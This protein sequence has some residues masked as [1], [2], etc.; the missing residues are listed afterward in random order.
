M[1]L[2]AGW[3]LLLARY[4]R[5]TDIV[6]G[7]P[8]ANRTRSEVEGLIGFFVNTLVLRTEVVGELRVR[9]LL[10]RVREVCLGAYGHQEVPFE[11]LVEELQPE[12]DL[13]HTPLF[14]VLLTLQNAPQQSVEWAGVGMRAL[15]LE[16]G[17]AK[18]DLTLVL[19]ETERGLAG[20]LEYNRDLY[21]RESMERLVDHYQRL[22]SGLLGKIEQPI[23]TLPW[24]S[25]AERAEVVQQSGGE[26]KEWGERDVVKLFEAEVRRAGTATA[27]VCGDEQISYEELNRRANQLAHYLRELGVGPE[28]K[29]GLLLSRSVAMV[30]GVLGV[31]KAGAA[32]LP[33][34]LQAPL[35]R[36][37]YILEDAQ[38]PVL[39]TEETLAEGVPAHWGQTIYLERDWEEFE[40]AE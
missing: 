27:V 37:A 16:S 32:Y 24:L 17:A 38:V 6:V 29:V 33:L 23:W 5:Q 31:L 39:L 22:L 7:S 9:E 8:I 11:M 30:V 10:Q 3:Q 20:T 34:E 25:E 18:F 28:V 19:A 21:E 35:A 15:E 1:T 26:E 14:Q 2:L 4:S 12:R 40:P 36:L 13:S